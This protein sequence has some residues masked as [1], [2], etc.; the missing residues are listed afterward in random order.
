MSTHA[1][2]DAQAAGFQGQVPP[3]TSVMT[4][5]IG[6]LVLSA[7]AYMGEKEGREGDLP[8]AEVAIDVASLAF[9]R[10]KERLTAEERLAITQL[11]TETRLA[12]VKRREG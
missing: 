3:V 4:E 1:A 5:V 11:L 9:E 7:H 10:V 12:F 8:S 6:M 2:P